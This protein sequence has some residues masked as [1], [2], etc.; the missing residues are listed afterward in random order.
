MSA[1]LVDSRPLGDG[2][3]LVFD[4]GD[5]LRRSALV[6]RGGAVQFP[7]HHSELGEATT[8]EVGREIR[9]AARRTV[10]YMEA[11]RLWARVGGRRC[12]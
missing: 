5:G 12:G 7:H 8:V 10:A 1:A 3:E 11:A 9:R 2:I 6:T 4:L